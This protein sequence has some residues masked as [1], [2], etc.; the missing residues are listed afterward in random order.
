MG[1]HLL[2]RV[3]LSWDFL[4][5][6]TGVSLSVSVGVSLGVSL[7][8][9]CE[10][11]LGVFPRVSLDSP[12]Q[13]FRRNVAAA[14]GRLAEVSLPW[15]RRPLRRRRNTVRSVYRKRINRVEEFEH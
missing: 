7:G 11:S 6:N 14:G 4:G 15:L 10:V 12:L 1:L 3:L 13:S 2:L 9:S 8:V 5:V